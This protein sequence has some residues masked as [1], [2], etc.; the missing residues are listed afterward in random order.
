[1]WL[2]GL[3]C[4]CIHNDI[5]FVLRAV[6]LIRDLHHIL[7]QM[8]WLLP[9]CNGSGI[10]RPCKW[11]SPILLVVTERK[12]I[13]YSIT[14]WDHNSNCILYIRNHSLVMFL[15][16]NCMKF[17]LRCWKE[18]LL[19][20]W[21]LHSDSSISRWNIGIILKLKILW[22][23]CGTFLFCLGMCGCPEK[24]FILFII[25]YTVLSIASLPDETDFLSM[26]LESN[27]LNSVCVI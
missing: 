22:W 27:R 6:R 17:F 16:F 2:L 7:K 20:W 25:I 19:A 9:G 26:S 3:L 11:Q 15:T 12:D 5:L 10:C 24:V 21:H 18:V 4:C 8:K 23:S 14:I 1:M 13:H